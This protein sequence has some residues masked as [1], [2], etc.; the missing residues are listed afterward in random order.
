MSIRIIDDFLEAEYFAILYNHITSTQFPWYY[1]DNISLPS[2][3]N[4]TYNKFGFDH[5]IYEEGMS[6]KDI[7]K[8][9]LPLLNQIMSNVE[10]S[11]LIRCRL[12]MTI[13]RN[14]TNP[15][16]AHVDFNIPH[17]TT[18]FYLMNSDGN[19]ILYNEEHNGVEKTNDDLTIHQEIEPKANRLLIFDGLTWH[20]GH[21]PCYNNRRILINTNLTY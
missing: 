17:I 4:T 2:P 1:Q 9:V 6:I 19:T 13:N 21:T 15:L 3:D 12:D 11:K 14:N 16:E 18:I 7:D 8:I 5:L 10:H 20:T